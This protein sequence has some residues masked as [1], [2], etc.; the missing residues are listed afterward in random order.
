[1]QRRKCPLRIVVPAALVLAAL[2]LAAACGGGDDGGEGAL[3]QEGAV[4]PDF[5]LP[6]ANGE[7]VTLSEVIAER[8]VLLY[9]S[10]G[11]G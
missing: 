3:I 9:F 5:R 6:A 1:M 8:S 10:M 2:T 7:M 11:S 4:A